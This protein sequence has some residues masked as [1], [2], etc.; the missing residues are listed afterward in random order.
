MVFGV[1]RVAAAGDSDN[2]AGI[3]Q[4]IFALYHNEPVCCYFAVEI[5][6]SLTLSL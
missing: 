6:D 3:N 1:V 4:A 5:I 2:Q